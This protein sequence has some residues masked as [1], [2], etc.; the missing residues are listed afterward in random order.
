MRVTPLGPRSTLRLQLLELHLRI[1]LG[2][3]LVDPD[4]VGRIMARGPEVQLDF[5]E[6]FV[7]TIDPQWAQF[8][9]RYRKVCTMLAGGSAKPQLRSQC[10]GR[11][12][13][14]GTRVWRG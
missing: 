6:T 14:G 12:R 2:Y 13:L 3:L 5:F 1:A 8:A 11:G 10:G 7:K 4:A 9:E